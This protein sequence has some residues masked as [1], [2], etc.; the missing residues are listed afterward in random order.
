MDKNSSLIVFNLDCFWSL[1]N[2]PF[3]F[4]ISFFLLFFNLLLFHPHI[5]FGLYLSDILVTFNQRYDSQLSAQVLFRHRRDIPQQKRIATVNFKQNWVYEICY[6]SNVWSVTRE[7]RF[8]INL[9]P[10]LHPFLIILIEFSIKFW[11]IRL[12]TITN[13]R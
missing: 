1:N 4:S 8:F 2:F 11:K 6:S 12:S 7:Q 3:I 5:M 9:N 10:F 13:I